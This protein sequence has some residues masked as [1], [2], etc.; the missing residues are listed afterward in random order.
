MKREKHGE[1]KESRPDPGFG[2]LKFAFSLLLVYNYFIMSQM[3]L[4]DE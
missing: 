1:K 2:I 3:C 4:G